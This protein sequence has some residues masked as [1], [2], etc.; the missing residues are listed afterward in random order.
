MLEAIPGLGGVLA[1][2]HGDAVSLTHLRMVTSA[3]ELALLPFELSKGPVGSG[4]I[5]DDWL[6]LQPDRPVCLTRHVRGVMRA[7]SWPLEP[8]DPVHQRS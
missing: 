3:A 4:G 2:D 1:T 8:T 7:T 5:G 6:L